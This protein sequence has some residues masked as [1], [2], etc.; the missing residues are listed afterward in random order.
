MLFG[1]GSAMF[2]ATVAMTAL[3]G[4]LGGVMGAALTGIF[5]GTAISSR[6]REQMRK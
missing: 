6:T 4:T 3:G 1:L 5:F 2:V